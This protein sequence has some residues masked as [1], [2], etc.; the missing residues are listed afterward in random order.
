VLAVT[1]LHLRDFA[2]ARRYIDVAKAANRT[3]AIVPQAWMLFS[4]NG[5][6]AGARAALEAALQAPRPA[7]ARVRGLLARLEWIDGR[8]DR[9]LQLI[10]AMDSA[11]AWLPANF[12]FPAAIARGQVLDSMGQGGR[13]RRSYADA[14]AG[15]QRRPADDY[16]VAAALAMAYAGLGRTEDA[17]RE[18]Q[19]GMQLL[20][21]SKDA[22]EAPVYAYTAALV[23]AHLGRHAEAYAVL[24]RM[25]EHPSFYSEAWV[26]RD[27][28]FATLRADP[29]YA[30]HRKQWAARKGERLL[31][32]QP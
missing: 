16:Q 8:Y 27:P 32:S 21:V 22:I 18:A 17:V 9:A 3:A 25:F 14:L 4:E 12:R 28:W 23:Y 30:S 19:R 24:D 10:D 6:V 29:A 2:N 20:P 7:D 13:A 26:D 11:G 15:L 5:E 1:Y 31:E